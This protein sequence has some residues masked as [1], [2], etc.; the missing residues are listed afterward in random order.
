MGDTVS[1]RGGRKKNLLS[2]AT[3]NWELYLFVLP[4]IVLLFIFH[5][6]PIYGIQIAFKDFS[7]RKGI[8]HSDFIGL[9]H[10]YRFF[11][12][13]H[14]T[15]ILTN[16]FRI[17]IST[18][19]FGFPAPVL[20]ALALNHMG[21]LKYKKFVQTVSYAPHF[22]STV[23]LC[24]MIY[25]FLSPSA[26]FVNKLIAFVGGEPKLFMAEPR[27]F[28]PVYVISGIW[29][30]TGWSTIIYLAAL[31]AINPE[32]YEAAIIDGAGKWKRIIHIDIPSIVPTIT[33]LL[34]LN[35][36]Y[37]L[38]VGFEKTFLLQTALNIS[39][40]EVI[41]TYV[42]KTGLLQAQFSFSAAVGLFNSVVNLA[43]LVSVNFLTRKLSDNS[44]W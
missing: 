40:S 12:S 44:L 30:H 16:T 5:Y 19:L 28:V 20:L 41:S 33:I 2:Y 37:L 7:I 26:G 38:S 42:Y 27:A 23:V 39:R 15:T 36:G 3:Q 6:L 24:G 25:L 21:S 1:E 13:A 29:Q 34:I 31:S 4:S 10:F 43:L 35:V 14:F 11:R 32:L 22:V 18:L 17:S 9:E 8:W